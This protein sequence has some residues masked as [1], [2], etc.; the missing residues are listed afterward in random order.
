[1]I[2]RRLCLFFFA[3]F[4][5]TLVKSPTNVERSSLYV[6][7]HLFCWNDTKGFNTLVSHSEMTDHVRDE[8]C[9]DAGP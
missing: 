8:S 4:N 1:M 9:K 3:V 5:S 7:D 2:A 6:V